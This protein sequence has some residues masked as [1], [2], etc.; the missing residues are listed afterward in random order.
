[1]KNVSIMR[2]KIIWMIFC[3][4][5]TAN[6]HVKVSQETG[7]DNCACHVTV[8]DNI[9]VAY[10]RLLISLARGFEFASD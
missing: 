4:R 7:D 6:F 10:R 5:N 2:K 9:A 1:M 8:F 3:G